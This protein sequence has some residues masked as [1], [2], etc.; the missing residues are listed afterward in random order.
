M[1][2]PVQMELP[3]AR[4]GRKLA[5]IH[6]TPEALL[7]LLKNEQPITLSFSGVPVDAKLT[8]CF[9]DPATSTIVLVVESESFSVVESGQPIYACLNVTVKRDGYQQPVIAL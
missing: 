4:A 9:Y 1:R 6:V 2:K 7:D 5:R 3:G 8:E